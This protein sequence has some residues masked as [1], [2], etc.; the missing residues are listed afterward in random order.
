MTPQEVQIV[1]ALIEHARQVT[2]TLSMDSPGNSG[3]PSG[4]EQT[5]SPVFHADGKISGVIWFTLSQAPRFHSPGMRQ[6][7]R[8]G[9]TS[10]YATARPVPSQDI[11]ILTAADTTREADENRAAIVFAVKSQKLRYRDILVLLR[12]PKIIWI[13]SSENSTSIRFPPS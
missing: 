1:Y 8:D 3:F 11:H 13:Y 6:F 9:L 12:N 5:L 4:M 2:L 10:P 7:T